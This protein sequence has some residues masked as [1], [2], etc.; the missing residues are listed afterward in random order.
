M[1][2]T[3]LEAYWTTSKLAAQVPRA[4]TLEASRMTWTKRKVAGQEKT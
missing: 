2:L 1:G 4:M 3:L